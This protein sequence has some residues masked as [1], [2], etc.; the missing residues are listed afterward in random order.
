MQYLRCNIWLQLGT[1]RPSFPSGGRGTGGGCAR[2]SSGSGR[3]HET[4][5]YKPSLKR[6][7]GEALASPF[8]LCEICG[9]GDRGG[10]EKRGQ[11]SVAAWSN[12]HFMRRKILAGVVGFEP[13]VHDTKNRCLTTWLHP[14]S[15]RLLTKGWGALQA[16]KWAGRAEFSFPARASLALSEGLVIFPDRGFLA[17]HAVEVGKDRAQLVLAFGAFADDHQIRR[18]G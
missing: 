2:P 8:F 11:P 4:E 12:G 15:G 10:H 3:R 9:S 16:P 18:V 6:E 1:P 14:S 17:D 5:R 13:T 7:T